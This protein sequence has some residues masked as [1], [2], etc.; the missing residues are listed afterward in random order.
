MELQCHLCQRLHSESCGQIEM[1]ILQQC[2]SVPTRG[3]RK[4]E[5]TVSY[6]K[7]G[8]KVLLVV[9][10]GKGPSLFSRNWLEQIQTGR[11]ST[12]CNQSRCSQY[13]SI[14]RPCFRRN[15]AP[16]EGMRQRLSLTQRPHHAFVKQD[17]FLMH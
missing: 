17:Q 1:W 11:R 10:K 5:V 7:Q 9:V 15:W 8:A 12:A 14:T 16:F 2:S 4:A 13:C 3:K 6:K